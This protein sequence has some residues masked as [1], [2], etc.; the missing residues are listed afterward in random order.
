MARKKKGGD[1]GSSSEEAYLIAFGSTMTILLALF[2]V[3][4]TLSQSQEAGF[5]KGTGSFVRALNTFGLAGLFSGTREAVDFES[6]SPHYQVGE[7]EGDKGGDKAEENVPGDVNDFEQ[8][9]LS[10][11]LQ[12]LRRQFE[13]SDQATE[14][15]GV[16]VVRLPGP[17]RPTP[18]HLSDQQRQRLIELL[19]LLTNAERR[20]YVEVHAPGT[21]ADGLQNAARVA[22][23]I[24]QEIAQLAQREAAEFPQIIPLGRLGPAST[25]QFTA[26]LLFVR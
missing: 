23:G 12:N 18:P 24:K 11:M 9:R 22:A 21:A 25:D 4:S 26:R 14:T 7:G 1:A 6:V 3:L 15:I 20:V 17:V 16:A 13:S 2:I 19:P 8:E 10:R 5:R